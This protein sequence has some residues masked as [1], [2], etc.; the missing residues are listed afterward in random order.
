VGAK[1]LIS[2]RENGSIFSV[3]NP[4]ALAAE[5]EFWEKQRVIVRGDYSW[6][7]PARQLISFSEEA[8]MP[9]GVTSFPATP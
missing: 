1:D 6:R 4:S 2:H 3:S 9:A 5:L 8:L 7:G